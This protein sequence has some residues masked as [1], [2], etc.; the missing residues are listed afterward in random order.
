MLGK[1]SSSMNSWPNSI[2]LSAHNSFAAATLL[3]L[4]C[5]EPPCLDPLAVLFFLH[6]QHLQIQSI[7]LAK[8]YSNT[9]YTIDLLRNS[10]GSVLVPTPT[11]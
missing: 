9:L 11:Y 10:Y 4:W 2:H 7:S 1:Y 3:Q 6:Q 5:E 8:R